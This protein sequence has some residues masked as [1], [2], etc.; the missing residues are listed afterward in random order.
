MAYTVAVIGL[1]V[2]GTSLGLAL[3]KS[4]KIHRIGHDR[5]P[6]RAQQAKKQGAVD[7][8]GYN[9]PQVVQKSHLI[10]L[11]E[12]LSHLE[13]TFQII[14]PALREG[15]VVMDFAPLKR[16]PAEWAARYLPAGCAYLGLK[17]SFNPQVLQPGEWRERADLFANGL[18]AVAAP[19]GTSEKT[20]QLAE[21]LIRTLGARPLFSDAEEIDGLFARAGLLPALAAAA[22]LHATLERPGW[23]EARKLAGRSYRAL[24]N[25]LLA[26]E[27]DDL[28]Q[29]SLLNRR[30]L[31][32]SV[33]DL[34]ASLQTLRACLENEGDEALENYLREVRAG[35]Q[36]WWEE[37]QAGLWE[38][39][40]TDSWDEIPSFGERLSQ[41]LF[42]GRKH[43]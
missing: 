7:E 37:R 24:L 31:L 2:V 14:G 1:D 4:E 28:E 18:I 39:P 21:D 5:Q 40:S 34:I 38:A 23:Q 17:P 15:S 25:A 43:R 12:P 42:G 8:I 30:N 10:L 27:A 29:A 36:K 41:S 16:A 22:M 26:E 9:L 19:Q 6:Q 3:G 20:L 11:T 13:E 32:R 35:G 33:D